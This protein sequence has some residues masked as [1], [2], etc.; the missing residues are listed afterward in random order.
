MIKVF[1]QQPSL[2]KHWIQSPYTWSPSQSPKPWVFL[3]HSTTHTQIQKGLS[4]SAETKK[5]IVIE[6]C[7]LVKEM[8]FWLYISNIHWRFWLSFRN[9]WQTNVS[10]FTL[11]FQVILS[12]PPL[13]LHFSAWRKKGAFSNSK[14][15]VI[16]ASPHDKRM[17]NIANIC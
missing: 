15:T 9:W 10:Y 8:C 7:H 13:S 14:K 12:H 3:L 16:C 5:Y 2:Q 4:I 17:S 1:V 6:K 11:E